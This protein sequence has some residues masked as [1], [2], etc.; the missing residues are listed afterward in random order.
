MTP[1]A[2]GT[3]GIPRTYLRGLLPRYG[4]IRLYCVVLITTISHGVR[5]L[6][7][8]LQFRSVDNHRTIARYFFDSRGQEFLR[9]KLISR[10]TVYT[11]GLLPVAADRN[12][13]TAQS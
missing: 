5:E 11:V 2:G 9:G 6:Q 1:Y 8:S 3:S 10:D 7:R 4:T 13:N 12:S